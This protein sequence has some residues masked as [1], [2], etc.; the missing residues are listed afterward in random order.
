[1]QFQRAHKPPEAVA[2]FPGGVHGV[3]LRP[4]KKT[5][6]ATQNRVVAK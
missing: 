4:F 5:T 3:K 1:M 6:I 2:G